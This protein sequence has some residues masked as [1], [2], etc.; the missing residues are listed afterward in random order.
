[1]VVVDRLS[2]YAHFISLSHPF[3]AKEVANVFVKEVVC[4]HGFPDSI[5]S[6]RD[7]KIL[8]NFWNEMFNLQ[9]T[10]LLKSSTYH[11]QTDGQSERVNRCLETYLRCFCSERQN[12]WSKFLPWAELWYNTSF[13]L[14]IHTTPYQALYGR[15]APA[16]ISYGTKKTSNDSVEQLLMERDAALVSLKEQ[17]NLAQQRMKRQADKKRRDVELAEGDWAYVK[18]RPYRQ[19]TLGRKRCEKLSSKFFGPYQVI[20][21]IGTVAYRLQLP[22]EALIHNVFHISQLKT[23]VPATVT[24]HTSLLLLSEDLEWKVESEGVIGVRV[25][26]DSQERGMADK[27]EELSKL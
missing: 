2:K 6:D 17:L 26:H 20:E 24:V 4:L 22:P 11:P 3:N 15:P 12:S 21:R 1:M 14:S 13:H 27:M 10:R 16:I 23:G 9:E 7:K 25:L 8:S 18:I 19:R 5:V